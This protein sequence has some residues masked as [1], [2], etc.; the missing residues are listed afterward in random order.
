MTIDTAGTDARCPSAA[1]LAS[2]AGAGQGGCEQVGEQTPSASRTTKPMVGR[3]SIRPLLRS[4]GGR[5]LNTY[6]GP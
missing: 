6:H 4:G 5:T 2:W 1:H 3:V